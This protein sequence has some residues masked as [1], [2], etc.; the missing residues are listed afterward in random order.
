MNISTT[1]GMNLGKWQ[2]MKIPT[3]TIA[4]RVNLSFKQKVV[5]TTLGTGKKWSLITV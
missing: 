2:V 5:T 1:L 3:M 4:I